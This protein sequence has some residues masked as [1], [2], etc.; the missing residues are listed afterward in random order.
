[1]L[2]QEDEQGAEKVFAYGSRLLSKPERCYC[3]TRRE[4]LAVVTFTRQFKPYLVGRHFWL[5]TN[6]GSLTWLRNFKEPEAQ[7]ARWLEQLSEFDF[8][9]VNRRGKSLVNADALSHLPCS[10]CGQEH[11]S[12]QDTIPCANVRLVEHSQQSIREA[13]LSNEGVGPILRARESGK[14]L[15]E[16]QLQKHGIFT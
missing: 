5:R 16:K 14:Q 3:V 13:Q 9:I 10:Q 2:S 8:E 15:M 12:N 11:D 6:H 4:L 7:L 1:M